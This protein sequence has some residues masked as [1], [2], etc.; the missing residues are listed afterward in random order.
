MFSYVQGY[1][2]DGSDSAYNVVARDREACIEVAAFLLSLKTLD[3]SVPFRARIHRK[4]KP[5]SIYGNATEERQY[6][7]DEIDRTG[8]LLS[9]LRAEDVTSCEIRFAYCPQNALFPDVKREILD[10]LIA[11]TPPSERPGPLVRPVFDDEAGGVDD[12]YLSFTERNV[13]DILTSTRAASCAE[14][15]VKILQAG[16]CAIEVGVGL[17]APIGSCLYMLYRM[18]DRFP[19]LHIDADTLAREMYDY[20]GFYPSGRHIYERIEPMTDDPLE[21]LR[22]LVATGGFRFVS[23]RNRYPHEAEEETSVEQVELAR[24]RDDLLGEPLPQTLG[25]EFRTPDGRLDEAQSFMPDSPPD[26]KILRSI[27]GGKGVL[28]LKAYVEF[29]R[30]LCAVEYFSALDCARYSTVSAYVD[31]TGSDEPASRI[32]VRFIRKKGG[33]PGL[34]IDVP[35]KVRAPFCKKYGL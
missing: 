14:N 21:T 12:L 33:A 4:R 28:D 35:P 5:Y 24:V 19:E 29:A 8:S 30:K 34:V 25:Y 7:Y 11:L 32:L 10:R 31:G 1:E 16:A 9:S 3:R 22:R 2:I 26:Y 13:E 18:K 6:V 20:D 27:T 15:T 17:G 23:K